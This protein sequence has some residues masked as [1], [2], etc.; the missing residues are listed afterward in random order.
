MK[1]A[2]DSPKEPSQAKEP[3]ATRK[4]RRRE[5]APKPNI[6]TWLLVAWLAFMGAWACKHF[7]RQW[8]ENSEIIIEAILPA[9]IAANA[10]ETVDKAQSE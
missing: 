8:A 10:T 3:H 5:H 2:S 6:A 7:Y 9:D 4:P 1:D